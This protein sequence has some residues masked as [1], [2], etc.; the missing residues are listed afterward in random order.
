VIAFDTNI[1]AYA[2]QEILSDNRHQQAADLINKALNTGAIIPVQVLSEFMNVCKRKLAIAPLD[3]ISQ[4]QDYLEVFECPQTSAEDVTDA[5]LLAEQCKLSYFDALIVTIARRNG[6]S[7]FLTEDM[8]D[9]LE[10]DGLRVVNPFAAANN[11][12]L[13]VYFAQMMS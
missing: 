12:V 4:V 10:V 7:M 6:A 2:Q 11:G 8:H 13:E 3:A 1:L 5:A 9:G